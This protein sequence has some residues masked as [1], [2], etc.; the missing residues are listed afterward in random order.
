MFHIF[1]SLK[2]NGARNDIIFHSHDKAR[3]HCDSLK[4]F[5]EKKS[6]SWE[7]GF[8]DVSRNLI[9]EPLLFTYTKK[10]RTVVP[11]VVLKKYSE[12]LT[13]DQ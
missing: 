2:R 10:S 6:Q 7:K 11:K 1:H 13:E 3:V 9:Y 8:W 5:F 4:R 12:E